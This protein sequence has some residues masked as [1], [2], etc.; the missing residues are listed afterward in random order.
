MG[1]NMIRVGKEGGNLFSYL[2][3]K[4]TNIHLRMVSRFQRFIYIPSLQL[5]ETVLNYPPFSKAKFDLS[6]IFSSYISPL[7]LQNVFQ[8]VRVSFQTFWGLFDKFVKLHTQGGR[9]SNR[10]ILIFLTIVRNLLTSNYCNS[11]YRQ[12]HPNSKEQTFWSRTMLQKN[13]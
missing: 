1:D 13:H 2:K 5:I 7:S 8:E 4:K 3:I 6:C 9:Q 11:T 12:L 10:V